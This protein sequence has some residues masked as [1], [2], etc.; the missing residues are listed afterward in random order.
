MPLNFFCQKASQLRDLKDISE[1]SLN[2]RLNKLETGCDSLMDCNMI[3]SCNN[4]ILHECRPV[5]CNQMLSIIS[6]YFPVKCGFPTFDRTDSSL[7]CYSSAIIIFSG[8]SIVF[9]WL[10]LRFRK[11]KLFTVA[12]P[13]SGRACRDRCYIL[14]LVWFIVLFW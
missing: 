13:W 3:N 8:S 11:I 7:H 10:L 6:F 4:Y 1:G 12:P 9:L 14:Q 2:T 5:H